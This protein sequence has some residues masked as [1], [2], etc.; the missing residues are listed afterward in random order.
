MYA[1]KVH[2]ILHEPNHKYKSCLSAFNVVWYPWVRFSWCCLPSASFFFSFYSSPSSLSCSASAAVS[3]SQVVSP[4]AAAAAAAAHRGTRSFKERRLKWN[5]QH[6]KTKTLTI[7][8]TDKRNN[9]SRCLLQRLPRPQ[10]AGTPS[11]NT[12]NN[13]HLGSHPSMY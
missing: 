5:K 10:D 9:S 7:F 12:Q 11:N 6:E 2:A 4:A 13:C 8:S 1:S 3:A